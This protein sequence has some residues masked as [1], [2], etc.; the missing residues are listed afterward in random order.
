M[1]YTPHPA[2]EFQQPFG[3]GR[4]HVANLGTGDRGMNVIGISFGT[5]NGFPGTLVEHISA[6]SVE[7]IRAASLHA[8]VVCLDQPRRYAVIIDRALLTGYL[9][10]PPLSLPSKSL[11]KLQLQL[12]ELVAWFESAD[13]AA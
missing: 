9:C 1:Q 5:E 13:A 7:G 2:P 12:E 3:A 6:H 11:F 8:G 10:A 4:R